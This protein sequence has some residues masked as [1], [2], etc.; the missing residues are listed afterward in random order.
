[1][2][3]K[4]CD[5]AEGFNDALVMLEMRRRIQ[6]ILETQRPLIT[7]HEC[8]QEALDGLLALR[9]RRLRC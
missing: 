6:E 2:L 5:R 7:F 3:A 8:E 1:M 4:L 9:R